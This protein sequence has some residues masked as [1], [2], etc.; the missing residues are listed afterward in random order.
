MQYLCNHCTAL[1]DLIVKSTF[2][3][4]YNH[5]NVRHIQI[6]LEHPQFTNKLA[7]FVIYTGGLNC[8]CFALVK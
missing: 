2:F 6:N 8:V 7:D 5:L 3:I 4:F 1:F